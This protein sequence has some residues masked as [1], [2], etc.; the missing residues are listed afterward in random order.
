MN[1]ITPVA[2]IILP[3]LFAACV[4]KIPDPLELVEEYATKANAHDI[5]GVMA[6]FAAEAQFELVGQGTLPDLQAVRALHEYDKG[7]RTT[8]IMENCAANGLT[9]TCEI[10]ET[11]DWLDAAGL[12]GVH[13]P[14]AI[15]TFDE[16]GRIQ[17]IT[18]TLAPEDG[19]ALG[20]VMAE[21]MPWLMSE[22]ALESSPLFGPGGQFLY[23]EANG[24]L[25]V[26]LLNEWQ[27]G[28]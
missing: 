6:M 25:V 1:L 23:S 24:Q 3:V 16:A 14:S 5:E 12:D 9:V 15:F 4:G 13:Y 11:N 27:A 28:K 10:F 19:A 18:S 17:R 2:V 22:R 26:E 8:L 7:I 20:A 21:F